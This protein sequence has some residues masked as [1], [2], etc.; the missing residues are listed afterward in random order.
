MWCYKEVNIERKNLKIF[1]VKL[2]S[3]YLEK[4][5]YLFVTYTTAKT[6]D[7]HLSYKV[8]SIHKSLFKICF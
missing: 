8:T 6:G 5:L 2:N 4:L 7:F 1:E 3:K